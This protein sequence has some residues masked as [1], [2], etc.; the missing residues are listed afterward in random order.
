MKNKLQKFLI[1]SLLMITIISIEDVSA[2]IIEITPFAGYQIGGTMKGYYGDIKLDNAMSYGGRIGVGLSTTTFVEFT[3]LRSDTEAKYFG[4]TD[5]TIGDKTPLSSNYIQL[6]G[7]QEMDMGVFS[8]FITLAGGLAVWSPKNSGDF[9]TYTQFAFSFGG[10]TKIWITDNIG[11]RLQA[12][13]LMPLV[14][15]GAGIGCGIGT[16]GASCGGGIYT[17]ITPFQG[18]FS[19]GLIIKINTSR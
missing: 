16:G 5:G 3:Y 11:F 17:R 7:L 12:T 19:G 4:Y 15:N 14:Y 18:E 8:P 10:G 2:Q 1:A 6:G 9:S 13:M